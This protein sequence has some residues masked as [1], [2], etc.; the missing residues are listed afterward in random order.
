VA[1]IWGLAIVAAAA[2]AVTFGERFGPL[3]LIG[4]AL[5]LAGLGVIVLP[6]RVRG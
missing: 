2:S 4:M 1:V 5:V 6:A 3:R